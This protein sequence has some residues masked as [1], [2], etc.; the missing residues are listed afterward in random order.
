[1]GDVSVS[2]CSGQPSEKTFSLSKDYAN[3]KGCEALSDSLAQT[4]KVVSGNDVTVSLEHLAA[5]ASRRQSGRKVIPDESSQ[6]SDRVCDKRECESD[7]TICLTDS[8]SEEEEEDN[9]LSG[10]DQRSNKPIMARE[11]STQTI[12]REDSCDTIYSGTGAIGVHGSCELYGVTDTSMVTSL[13]QGIRIFNLNPKRG[14]IFI[15]KKGLVHQLPGDVDGNARRI[16]IFLRHTRGLNKEQIGKVLTGQSAE[17]QNILKNYFMLFDFSEMG[18]T[19]AGVERALRKVFSCFKP[20]GEAQKI[21]RVVDIF[22]EKFNDD[23]NMESDESELHGSTTMLLSY[24]II[25]LNVDLHNPSN[26]RKMTKREFVSNFK[27][28]N[29]GSDLPMDKM[30]ELYDRV[31]GDEIRHK[32]DRDEVAGNLFTHPDKSGWL[33]K[34]GATKFSKWR[35]RWFILSENTLYYFKHSEDVEPLGFIPLENVLIRTC[36]ETEQEDIRLSHQMRRALSIQETM[37][38]SYAS[39]DT[40]N[41]RSVESNVSEG[42]EEKQG[43]SD[44]MSSIGSSVSFGS[45]PTPTRLTP[46]KLTW[47][48]GKPSLGLFL[49]KSPSSPR[50]SLSSRSDSKSRSRSRKFWFELYPF[51]ERL[52]VKSARMSKTGVLVLGQHRTIKLRASSRQEMDEWV[53]L[54]HQK[55]RHCSQLL[56]LRMRTHQTP[57]SG[58]TSMIKRISSIT[59]SPNASK[60]DPGPRKS[61]RFFFSGWYGSKRNKNHTDIDKIIN[62]KSSSG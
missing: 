3:A 38:S 55:G 10:K 28:L 31:L 14:I 40:D 22:A 44:D 46:T 1:M 54:L 36:L 21:Q 49:R 19:L 35:P 25:L 15:Q 9:G 16:A 42:V 5:T 32:I 52:N 30:G 4:D 8:G 43:K 2:E 20:P 29:E 6:D 39:S 33:F 12:V 59:E 62:V 57:T 51:D 53:E 27:G 48:Q 50:P 13:N 24:S 58:A 18:P 37:T 7:A 26:P 61:S 17:D 56:E 60:R 47:P 45:T 23:N 41:R 11:C 34:K